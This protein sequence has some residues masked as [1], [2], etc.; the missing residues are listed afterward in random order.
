VLST[1][2]THLRLEAAN[3]RPE[4]VRR[5]SIVLAPNRGARAVLTERLKE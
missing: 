3:S 1:I 5:R 4:R 2:L